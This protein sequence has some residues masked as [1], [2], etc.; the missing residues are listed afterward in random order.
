MITTRRRVRGVLFAAVLAIAGSW[1]AGVA[2]AITVTSF[3]LSPT[4]GPPGAVVKISGHGCTPA[5][6]PLAGNDYVKVTAPALQVSIQVPVAASGSWHGSFTVP[7]NATAAPG[8][9]AAL[10]VTGGWPALTTIYTPQTF[11]VIAPPPS[12]T[13][14]TTA[15]GSTTP[16]TPTTKP[17]ATGTAP[18]PQENPPI[19]G[20][21]GS[22]APEFASVPPGTSGGNRGS[23]N[24]RPGTTGRSNARPGSTKADGSLQASAIRAARAADLS[25]P[26]L[27]GA[28]VAA[29]GG[30]GWLAWLL[31]LS[32]LIAAVG[33]PFWLRRSR[34]S[35]ADSAAA[36]VG[37]TG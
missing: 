22:T 33:A 28:R 30:L 11:T 35:E 7:A 1:S 34:R 19:S 10:C 15:P 12:T 37:D 27:P 5:L 24:S 16:T 21:P 17:D 6:T 25:V 13:P 4:S 3:R 18:P 26:E 36:S 32:L 9:V 29:G 2:G 20:S 8:L 14:T 23:D 31:L